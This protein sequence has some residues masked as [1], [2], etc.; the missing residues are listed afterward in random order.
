MWFKLVLEN[1]FWYN[2]NYCT[3]CKVK[4]KNR[5]HRMTCSIFKNVLYITFVKLLNEFKDESCAT[6]Y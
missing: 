1:T 3:I 5:L 6:V 4:V 2:C